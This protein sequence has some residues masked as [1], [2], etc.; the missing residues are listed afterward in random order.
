MV[1]EIIYLSIY[2]KLLKK[3]GCRLSKQESGT[4]PLSALLEFLL[5]FFFTTDYKLLFEINPFLP[6]LLLDTMFYHGSREK[7]MTTLNFT[8]LYPNPQSQIGV[9]LQEERRG[10]PSSIYPSFSILPSSLSD[11]IL[12]SFPRL[13]LIKETAFTPH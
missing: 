8:Y 12:H 10:I 7:S 4:P 2:C 9:S 13:R 6:T 11:F 5:W 3:P 1:L